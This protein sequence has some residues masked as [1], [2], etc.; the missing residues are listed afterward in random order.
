MVIDMGED[1]FRWRVDQNAAFIMAANRF[2]PYL[3]SQPKTI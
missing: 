2:P 1:V 3:L